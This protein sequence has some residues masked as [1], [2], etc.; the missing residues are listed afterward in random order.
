MTNKGLI[1]VNTLILS[2]PPYSAQKYT[3]PTQIPEEHSDKDEEELMSPSK[4]G[5]N[6]QKE[7]SDEE[8]SARFVTVEEKD[9]GFFN[10]RNIS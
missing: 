1:V 9:T 5:T 7:N 4:K 3:K 6:L 2:K 8:S 10:K